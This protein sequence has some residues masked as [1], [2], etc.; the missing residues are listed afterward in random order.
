[1]VFS[2]LRSAATVAV[3]PVRLFLH[4]YKRWY[5]VAPFTVAFMTCYIKGS[6]ADFLAQYSLSPH[7]FVEPDDEEGE[8]EFVFDWR[9]NVAFGL[10]SGW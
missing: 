3:Q 1:M 6:A 2:T 7:H 10:F 9:R 8:R 4:R 5:D